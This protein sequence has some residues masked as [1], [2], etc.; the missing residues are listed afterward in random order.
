MGGRSKNSVQ[1]LEVNFRRQV[2]GGPSSVVFRRNWS[3]EEVVSSMFAPHTPRGSSIFSFF[4]CFL[5]FSFLIFLSP[6]PPAA[7][8][9]SEIPVSGTLICCDGYCQFRRIDSFL[10]SCTKLCSFSP[11]SAKT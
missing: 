1:R 4:S 2:A 8:I 3:T 9:C 10:G 11:I 7:A 5:S 6:P